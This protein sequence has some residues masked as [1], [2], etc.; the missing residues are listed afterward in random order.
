MGPSDAELCA[1]VIAVDDRHAFA[2]LVRRHQAPVRALLRRL[3]CGD[4]ALADDL[5]Q[6]TFLRAY[7]A[8][9]TWRGGGKLSSWLYAI[10]HRAFLSH[11]RTLAARPTEPVPD[12][13]CPPPADAAHARHDLERAL[14]VL[15]P[16]ERAALA[17]TY[18]EDLTHEEAAAVL[19]VP[20]G[21][22][23]T[24]VLGAKNKLRAEL[25]RDAARATEER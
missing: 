12:A 18:A 6:D 8:L 11:A 2:T 10:A 23:K 5:A 9:P 1:R 21:T 3:A 13:P 25:E 4:Q 7:H 15:A 16:D 17:L 22:L 20:L 24:R 14:R 19:D